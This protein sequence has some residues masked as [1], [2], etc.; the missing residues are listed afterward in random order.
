MSSPVTEKSLLDGIPRSLAALVA[1]SAALVTLLGSAV[2][3]SAACPREDPCEPP[4]IETD[5][6]TAVLTVS[7]NPAET[8]QSVTF[9]ASAST[10]GS[11]GGTDQSITRY[12]WNADGDISNGY[13]VDGGTTATLTRSYA[14]AGARSVGVRVTSDAGSDTSTKTLTVRPVVTFDHPDDRHSNG[15][16]TGYYFYAVNSVAGPVGFRC[17]QNGGVWQACR[18]GAD[19]ADPNRSRGF[20]L[21]GSVQSPL[22][23]GRYTLD[24]Q[25]VD[26]NGVES[27]VARRSFT[28]DRTP[29]ANPPTV[30]GGPAEGKPTNAT[31][32]KFNFSS[33]E[34]GVEF[35][36]GVNAA[37]TQ[38]CSARTATRPPG[39]TMASTRSGSWRSTGPG[40]PA[41][42]PAATGRSTARRRRRA[43]SPVPA[44]AQPPS[45]QA[46][47][48]SS[49]ALEVSASSAESTAARSD[50]APAR[51][52]GMWSPGLA[53]D[54]TPSR[55]GR[56]T[57][58]GTRI[59]RP[60]RARGRS[61]LRTRPPPAP[62]SPQV[63]PGRC[64]R[65]ARASAS[66]RRSRA[67]ASSAVA[68]EALG[69]AADRPRP[70][71]G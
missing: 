24:V 33:T 27:A 18:L 3:A 53:A 20:S 14:L 30:T 57:P 59:R 16:Y 6:A 13:E 10:G 36:C 51:V 54:R 62:R 31:S 41:R 34:A 49:R 68:I 11:T 8:G 44:R 42:W 1:L 7:P 25:A 60:P 21:F 28:I 67:R 70:T 63:P 56:S 32:A 48:S 38:P 19:P 37:P 71:P 58:P 15:P 26:P 29:P 39:S 40:T 50:P 22:S 35:R 4:P 12:E 2:A 45:R 5:P 61:G 55:C 52:T 9:D 47:G 69:R 65:R 66:P 64:A 46:Q 17:S 43:S 23:E